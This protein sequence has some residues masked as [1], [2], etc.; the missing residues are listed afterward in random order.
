[1][2][3][4]C[5]FRMSGTYRFIFMLENFFPVI[6]IYSIYYFYQPQKNQLLKKFSGGKQLNKQ[7]RRCMRKMIAAALVLTLVGGFIQTV[8]NAFIGQNV[9]ITAKATDGTENEVG[10]TL[11]GDGIL[12]LSAG[13]YTNPVFSDELAKNQVNEIKAEEGVKFIRSCALKREY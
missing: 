2:K 9:S 4:L 3:V 12:T 8:P 1:M 6:I 10:Y 11:D 13:T 7:F 5:L